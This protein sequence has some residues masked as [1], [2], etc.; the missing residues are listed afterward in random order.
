MGKLLDLVENPV[1][2]YASEMVQSLGNFPP[3]DLRFSMLWSEYFS[4]EHQDWRNGKNP[5]GMLSA[6][7][8]TAR[9]DVAQLVEQPIRN[10][11]VTSSSLVVGSIPFAARL[12][13]FRRALAIWGV[14]CPWNASSSTSRSTTEVIL[15]HTRCRAIV[16][17]GR[18]R[19]QGYRVH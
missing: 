11:Q 1:D 10:R 9:A 19:N 14:F 12:R 13:W 5:V 6:T 16:R 8:F 7:I 2:S 3:F 15:P 17:H 4:N 18:K